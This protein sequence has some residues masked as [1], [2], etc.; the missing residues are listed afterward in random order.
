MVGLPKVVF[1]ALFAINFLNCLLVLWTILKLVYLLPFLGPKKRRE[2]ISITISNFCF[3]N[4]MLRPCPWVKLHGVDELINVLKKANGAEGESSP[5]FLANH[6]SKLDS[7]L[8]TGI[9]PSFITN[10]MRSLIKLALFSEPLFGGVCKAVGH[11]PVYYKGSA[12]GTSHQ[13]SDFIFYR[14]MHCI[15]YHIYS[16]IVN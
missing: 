13:I 14:C 16:D 7:L 15:V 9:F 1:Q 12:S 10:R 11:F 4:L 3:R 6:N 2:S 8:I 5:F